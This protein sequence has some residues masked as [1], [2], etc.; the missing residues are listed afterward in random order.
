MMSLFLRCLLAVIVAVMVGG[1]WAGYQLNSFYQFDLRAITPC[2]ITALLTALLCHLV[3]NKTTC[4]KANEGSERKS[5]TP[6]A[7]A[8]NSDAPR[9]SGT[10]KWFNVSK[11]F[12]FITRENGEDI[13]VHYRN[14]RG[15]GRR[16]LFDGQLVEFSVTDGDKGLQA[17]DIEIL[18]N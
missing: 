8:K 3:G 2:L 13:F 17:D 11:G 7:A 6:K 16:R 12:G 1:F 4:A 5:S 9:E 14:I 15:E 18:K 10:V